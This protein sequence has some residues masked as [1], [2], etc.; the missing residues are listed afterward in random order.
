MAQQMTH[1]RFAKEIAEH[2]GVQS[3]NDYLAGAVYPDTRYFTRLPREK[4]HD[5]HAPSLFVSGLSDFEKGWAS[6][7]FYD[8]TSMPLI[9]DLYPPGVPE[10]S[11]GNWTWLFVIA[12]KIIEDQQSCKLFDGGLE[13]M[14]S[15]RYPLV[16]H[17]ENQAD[18]QAF[19]DAQVHLYEQGAGD[20]AYLEL[21][22]HMRLTD[23]LAAQLV[24]ILADLRAD[25]EKHDSILSIFDQVLT[26]FSKQR[27]A[28]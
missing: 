9:M 20:E 12:V 16:P 22:K 15:I 2:L 18:M 13:T 4:T 26:S 19:L 17:A 8:E 24:Q 11:P 10:A 25:K 3:M 14:R 1:L 23:E 6:H 21:A 7:H 27:Q 5:D 28:S